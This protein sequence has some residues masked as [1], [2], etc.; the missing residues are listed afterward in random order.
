MN[1]GKYAF[2]DKAQ[3]DSKVE[4]LYTYDKNKGKSLHK[5]RNRIR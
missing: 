5:K 3:F 2:N 1:I 4:N